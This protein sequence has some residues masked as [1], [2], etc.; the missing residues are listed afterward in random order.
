MKK[1]KLTLFSFIFFLTMAAQSNIILFDDYIKPS[2]ELQ[3]V[4]H[5]SFSNKKYSDAE[6][7]TKDAIALFLRLSKEDIERY[8]FIQAGNYY[9]LACVYSLKNNAELAIDAFSISIKDWGY[10]DYS[11]A[12]I[13]SDLDNIRD[14]KRFVDLMANIREKGDYLFILQQSG[15]YNSIDTL[16]LPN[17]DYENASSDRLQ[18]VRKFFQLDSI[19]GQGDEMSKIIKIM[20]WIHNNIKHD[21][22]NFALCEF[23]A[24]DFY[25]YYKSTGKGINCRALAIT[26]NECYLSMGFKSRFITCLPKNENDGDCHV[27][28]IVYSND[29]N[30]WVWMDPTFNAYVK[31]ENGVFLSIE[32]VREY[33]KNGKTLILN[34]D[35]NWNNQNPQTKEEYL[36]TY[37]AKNLYWLQCP[38]NSYFNVESRYRKIDTKYISLR[39]IGY[40]RS[41]SKTN[42]IIIN[43]PRYFWQLPK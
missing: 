29:L 35:A 5:E 32:E 26:L 39:P 18:S 20:T 30:K 24:I 11:H 21:G 42:E 40:K 36:D 37:M 13:D 9:N 12:K 25:N 1:I 31:D 22:G 41:D 28:N 14:D 43:D 10:L 4:I 8:K 38:L 16:G 15:K 2:Q 3:K 17:F 27:I 34:K 23:D 7:Y 33:I 19:A 6:K